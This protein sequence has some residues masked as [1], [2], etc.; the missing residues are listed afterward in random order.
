MQYSQSYLSSSVH[1]GRLVV[2]ARNRLLFA[3]RSST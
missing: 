1:K 2:S 3:I